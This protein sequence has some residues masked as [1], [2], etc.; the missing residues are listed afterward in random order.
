[1]SDCNELIRERLFALQ[2]ESYRQFQAKLM[3]TVDPNTIIGVR[4][5]LLRKL[6]KELSAR[7]DI[8]EF[9][10]VLPHP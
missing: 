9:L 10:A 6:A 3:P 4:T 1:M 2:D 7:Q 5:P 8:G